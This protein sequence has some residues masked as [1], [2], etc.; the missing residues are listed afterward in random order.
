[1]LADGYAADGSDCDGSDL[2]RD[3]YNCGACGVACPGDQ[4]CNA[5]ICG[6]LTI[7]W[8]SNSDPGDAGEGGSVEW[9]GNVA[10]ADDGTAYYLTTPYS[11]ARVPDVQWLH[12]IAPDGTERWRV[13]LQTLSSD[14]EGSIAPTSSVTI[15]DDG[16]VYTGGE[17]LDIRAAQDGSSLGGNTLKLQGQCATS[18]GFYLLDSVGPVSVLLQSSGTVAPGGCYESATIHTPAWSENF[19]DGVSW[20]A[21]AGVDDTIYADVGEGNGVAA[22]SALSPTDGSSRWSTTTCGGPAFFAAGGD[23]YCYTESSLAR[24]TAEGTLI[25]TSNYPPIPPPYFG[26][27][28]I[29]VYAGVV[30]MDGLVVLASITP[31]DAGTNIEMSVVGLSPVDGTLVWQV[32]LPSGSSPGDFWVTADGVYV[33][34]TSASPPA[35]QLLVVRNHQLASMTPL[36]GPLGTDVTSLVGVRPDGVALLM[37]SDSQLYAIQTR[38]IGG[39]A[40]TSWPAFAHDLR[41]TYRAK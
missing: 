31:G 40:P 6:G 26:E 10:V 18:A 33:T 28:N 8:Q 39:L 14:P 34:A 37:G 11:P 29:Y 2:T 32:D 5:G 4:V 13:S 23:V 1:M 19:P 22:L 35:T 41:W 38:A 24:Y 30:D 16:N 21:V 36:P 25:F 12:A 27:P 7:L 20:A 15:G 9:Q 17:Y 3:P